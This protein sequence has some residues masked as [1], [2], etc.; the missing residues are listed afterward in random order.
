MWHA[1]A[2]VRPV[3]RLHT[4][5]LARDNETCRVWP[6]RSTASSVTTRSRVGHN[7]IQFRTVL[8]ECQLSAVRSP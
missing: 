6:C 4:V 7:R 1:A 8:T 5:R 2:S 3:Y